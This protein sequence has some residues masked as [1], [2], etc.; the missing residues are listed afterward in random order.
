MKRNKDHLRDLQYTIKQIDFCLMEVPE[1]EERER[2]TQSLWGN[3]RQKFP[4]L[5]QR[6]RHPDQA[7]QRIPNEMNAM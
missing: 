4:Y 1:T 5:R 7:A 2:G 6:N 3:N